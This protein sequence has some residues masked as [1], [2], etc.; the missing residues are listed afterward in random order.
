MFFTLLFI[1]FLIIRFRYAKGGSILEIEVTFKDEKIVLSF[2]SHLIKIEDI[3]KKLNL[4]EKVAFVVK[5][6]EIAGMKDGVSENDNI[7][8]INVVSGG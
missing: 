7:E 4:N 6:N 3:L 8:I 5:N 2:E 1:Y